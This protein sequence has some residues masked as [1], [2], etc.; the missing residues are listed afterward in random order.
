MAKRSGSNIKKTKKHPL[1]TALKNLQTRV[2]ANERARTSFA[3]KQA[4]A[5]NKAQGKGR[6]IEKKRRIEGEKRGEEDGQ[7]AQT[8]VRGKT[9]EQDVRFTIPFEKDDRILL[10]GEGNFSFALSL[11]THHLPANTRLAAQNLTATSFDTEPEIHRK[12]PQDAATN[13]EALRKA[14]VNV[15][16]SVDATKLAANKDIKLL[17]KETNG[18]ENGWNKVVFNFPHAGAGITDQDRNIATNQKL[19]LGFLK[20]VAPL[21]SK[22]V[23]PRQLRPK[24]RKRGEDE[25]SDNDNEPDRIKSRKSRHIVVEDNDGWEGLEIDQDA[26]GEM[27]APARPA[28]ARQGVVL[29]TLRDTEPY[30]SW[31]LPR[32]AK[33][34]PPNPENPQPSYVQ[35][36]SYR[37]YPEAYPGYEHRRTIGYVKDDKEAKFG[38]GGT[39]GICRTWEF[40]LKADED[41]AATKKKKKKI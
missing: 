22:G 11:L 35:L 19:L 8:A 39:G 2:D 40:V 31:D 14:G 6:H 27:D 12:Y 16:C 29:V 36:R 30:T 17:L 4:A 5:K 26:I 38:V 41:E 34:P 13:V 10:I 33:R 15:L 21:L 7:L 3:Q 9:N 37:F 23:V 32:L 28:P 20:S 24:K 25:D 1:Q 18:G